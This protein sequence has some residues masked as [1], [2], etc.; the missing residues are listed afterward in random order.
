MTAIVA[1][2]LQEDGRVGDV[3]AADWWLA[4]LEVAYAT[5]LRFGTLTHLEHKH[6][7]RK[8]AVLEVPGAIMKNR[9]G[10]KF[11]LPEDAMEAVGAIWQPSRG[12]IFKHH[13]NS[14]RGPYVAWQRILERAGIEWSRH[15]GFHMIRRT[16]ATWVAVKGGMVAAMALLG[17]SEDYVARRYVDPTKIPGHNVAAFLPPI[18]KPAALRRKDGAT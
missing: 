15:V 17:H 6:L 2:V 11:I 18:P 14:R 12:L 5:A 9:R 10:K 7:N 4:F 13:W 16:S 8:T 1:S 3:P